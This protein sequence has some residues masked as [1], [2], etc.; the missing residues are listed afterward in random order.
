MELTLI[1]VNRLCGSLLAGMYPMCGRVPLGTRKIHP[2]SLLKWEVAG[3][4]SLYTAWWGTAGQL[5][6]NSHVWA[7]HLC[8][9][10]HTLHNSAKG[11]IAEVVVKGQ[12][13][14]LLR[15]VMKLL[16]WGWKQYKMVALS[17]NYKESGDACPRVLYCPPSGPSAKGLT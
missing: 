8:Y 10:W 14:L 1:Q 2:S 12:I 5:A 15:E 17:F 4:K 11:K 13:L 16:N 9:V 7:A 3:H 6:S